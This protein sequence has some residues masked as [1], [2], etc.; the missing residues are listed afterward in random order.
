[1][2]TAEA[3]ESMLGILFILLIDIK[4]SVNSVAKSKG[5]V[6]FVDYKWI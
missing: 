4:K 3:A 2:L 6:V 5:L 1:M